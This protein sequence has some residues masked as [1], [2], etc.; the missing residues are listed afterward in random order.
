MNNEKKF[1]KE[2]IIFGWIMAVVF[3]SV[4]VGPSVAYALLGTFGPVGESAAEKSKNIG[5]SVSIFWVDIPI[6]GTSWDSLTYLISQAA[7]EAMSTEIDGYI[8]QGF[9]G[10]PAFAQDPQKF[11]QQNSDN[12]AQAFIQNATKSASIAGAAPYQSQVN[13][14]VLQNYSAS[15][16]TTGDRTPPT[17][18][19]PLSGTTQSQQAFLNGDFSQGGW[20]QWYNM[21][22]NG[23]NAYAAT[24]NTQ[25][26][27]STRVQTSQQ[28]QQ[29]L[30]NWA[31]GFIGK[32]IC[33]EKDANGN[34]T[35]NGPILTPGSTISAELNTR[36]GST[37][38]SLENV[39]NFTELLAD[40]LSMVVKRAIG[41][42][43]LF[44]KSSTY[45]AVGAP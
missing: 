44:T 40:V 29:S 8:N 28:T 10:G 1:H 23:G 20:D 32:S 39:H 9:R 36:L 14:A 24:I 34:C 43:G 37:I 5:A 12:V 45:A 6:P 35:K 41:G 30:L 11:F 4:S 19:N 7:L 25:S 42:S 17:L 2:K 27:L 18:S 26:Q 3:I 33:I 38:N 15:R 21:T 16:L 31:N 13:T 22:Q